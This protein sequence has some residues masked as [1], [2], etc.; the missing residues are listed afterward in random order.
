MTKYVN[1]FVWCVVRYMWQHIFYNLCS[2]KNLHNYEDFLQKPMNE[3]RGNIDACS[4]F[5]YMA[6]YFVGIY[7]SVWY[8]LTYI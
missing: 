3:G 4:D 5:I 8:E 7:E 1:P 2:F 6:K